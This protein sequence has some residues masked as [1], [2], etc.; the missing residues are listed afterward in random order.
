MLTFGL[1]RASADEAG[2]AAPDPS[3]FAVSRGAGGGRGGLSVGAGG[4]VARG[5]C[6]VDADFGLGAALAGSFPASYGLTASG[7]WMSAAPWAGFAAR[8]G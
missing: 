6:V 4:L 8:A 1:S 3:A 5:P 7:I 2:A